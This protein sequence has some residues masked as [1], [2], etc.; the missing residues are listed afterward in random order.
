MLPWTREAFVPK[1]ES[2]HFQRGD[3]RQPHVTSRADSK[4]TQDAVSR[5]WLPRR[6]AGLCKPP[7]RN[8]QNKIPKSK[9]RRGGTPPIS[10][11]HGPHQA[12]PAR[13]AADY[14]KGVRGV[15]DTG[16]RYGWG[17]WQRQRSSRKV[18]GDE[19]WQG[20]SDELRRLAR[21]PSR[22]GCW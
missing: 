17:V 19:S 13:G 11:L 4:A 2:T 21:L 1:V 7:S 16:S 9:H 5:P 3:P 14:G 10:L 20:A 6:D 18:D 8:V 15:H 12:V 22:P